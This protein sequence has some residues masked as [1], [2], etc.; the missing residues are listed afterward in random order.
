MREFGL[1]SKSPVHVCHN[2]RILVVHSHLSE[3][4]VTTR[5]RIPYIHTIRLSKSNLYTFLRFGGVT[6][7]FIEV[8]ISQMVAKLFIDKKAE[9]NNNI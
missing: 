7:P 9:D 1:D 5:R 8:A 3:D 4:K 2:Q 6:K